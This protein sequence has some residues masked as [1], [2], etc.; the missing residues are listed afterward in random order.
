MLKRHARVLAQKHRLASGRDSNPLLA[1][2]SANEQLL[3]D[4]NEQ[5]LL[6]EKKRRI[7]PAAEWLLDNFYLIEE[8]IRMARRH[9]PRGFS[10]E[11]PRLASGPSA[12][13]PRVYDLAFELIS[14]VDGRVD[15]EHLTGFIAGYQEIAPL[16]LGELWAVPIMLR[17]ALIENL[18]RIAALLARERKARDS[19]E[20]WADRLIHIAE[21]EPEKQIIEVA[22]L[23]QSNVELNRAFVAQFWSRLQQK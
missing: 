3:Q 19:A 16:Q 6:V 8:Q 1:R 2:L 11:L 10:R 9:L 5:T 20:F 12:N 14:H 17:L 15:A 7:T 13:L 18:R 23:A 4:Y 22:R 21:T